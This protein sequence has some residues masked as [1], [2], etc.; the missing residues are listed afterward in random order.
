MRYSEFYFL[1]EGNDDERFLNLVVV[2]IYQKLYDYVG[3]YKYANRPK[4]KVEQFLLN[5]VKRETDFVCLS[6]IDLFPCITT[7]KQNLVE[8][9]LGNI[10]ASRIVIVKKE[11]ES[12]YLAGASDKS[13]KMLHMSP[14][15]IKD[16]HDKEQFERLVYGSKFA[17][18]ID[19]MIEILKSY[20][21]QYAR[22]N[23]S[24]FGYFHDKFLV[25]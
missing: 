6:D 1:V 9:K 15:E 14:N 5:L 8:H 2:P 7:R 13:C 19:C 10:D 16:N 24:S 20:N 3:L 25:F 21:I 17:D 23:N 22:K 11:I 12:W 18:S 4:N